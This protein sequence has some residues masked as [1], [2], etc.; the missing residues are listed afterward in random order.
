MNLKL[1]DFAFVVLVGASGSGKSTFARRHFKATEIISSDTCRGLVSDDENS[2]AATG[3][4]FDLVHYIATKRLANLKTVVVDATS[5]RREDRKALL[6]LAKTYHCLPVAIIFDLP[7]SVSLERNRSRPERDF[8]PHVVR[9]QVKNLKRGLKGFKREGFRYVYVLQLVEEVDAVRLERQPLWT[10]K[11]SVPG[12]FDIVGDVHGCA[13]ELE[14]LLE[15]LGYDYE[16]IDARY[17][18]VYSHPSRTAVFLGDLM[19]RGPRNLDVYG[20]VRNMVDTGA[21]LC[22][23][24]NHDVKLLRKLKGSNVQVTHGLETT[25]AELEALPRELRPTFENE[26]ATFLDGLVSHYLLDDGKLV[27]AHAGLREDL[28]GRASG[29]VRSFALYGE[30]TGETDEFGLPVR[31]NWAR[32]YRGAATVVY[33]H[34]PVPEALWLNKTINID[35]GCVFGGKLSALRYPENELVQVS[36]AKVYAE[37][38]KPFLTKASPLSTR[39]LSVQTLSAQQQ[40]DDVLDL[41]DV[42]GKRLVVTRYGNVTL[43]AENSAAALE[44]MSRFAIN[45]KWLVYL[46]P[47]MT[48]PKTTN[49]EGLLEHPDEAFSYYVSEGISDLVCQEKH[50]GSRA[51]LVV[52]RDEDAARRRFGLIG[53]GDGICYTRTG[54]PFFGD[55]ALEAAL[56]D[57]VREALTETGFWDTLNTD[58]ALLDTEMMPWS[59]KAQGLLETQY[60][61]VGAAATHG[62]GSVRASLSKAA[63]RGVATADLLAQVVKREEAVAAYRSAYRHYCW[64]VNSVDDL[65]LAPFH[66]LATEG[67]VHTDKP[68]TWHM[69]TL[70]T[71][72]TSSASPVLHATAYRHVDLNDAE[73]VAAAVRWWETLTAVGSEGMVVKP[74]SFVARGKRGLAQPA[75]KVRGRDYLRIIYGPEYS[76]PEHLLRLRARNVSAKRS[77]AVREFALGLEALH[78]FSDQEPLRRVHECVF[79]VL[80]LESEAVNPRL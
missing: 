74:I 21:A 54:R 26:L 72:L 10:D 9:N 43:R 19:D 47:T 80:A 38:A 75:V 52:C 24:G 71:H 67:A 70:R 56:L 7:E 36:A 41:E 2:L 4:A 16:T 57:R 5:V 33:G 55:K 18:R 66:L 65:K 17:P 28:Q 79:G 31:Y 14:W 3:D 6:K 46:P 34:T 11:R 51:L 45:P 32:D 40:G 20:L 76:L 13:D 61:A 42:T 59:A 64:P 60:A 39:T 12:P 35:T 50:M 58:W 77:L 27:V 49:R 53:E 29:A 37:P 48:A 69:E 63:A 1:P 73:S 30:T 62:L 68:H 8:G 23:P 78:R 44:T 25:L 22:V 15:K